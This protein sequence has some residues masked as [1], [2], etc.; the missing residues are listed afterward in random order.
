VLLRVVG[1]F[2]V[3]DVARIMNRTPGSVRVLCHRALRRLATTFSEG[4]PAP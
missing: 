4:V 1:G 3:P 2:D